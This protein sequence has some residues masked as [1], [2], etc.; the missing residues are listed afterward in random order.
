MRASLAAPTNGRDG[1]L[2]RKTK[3]LIALAIAIAHAA[4]AVSAFTRK[5]WSGSVPPVRKEAVDDVITNFTRRVLR[6]DETTMEDRSRRVRTLVT[7]MA[8]VEA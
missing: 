2:D 6:E 3:E 7:Q 8:P 4:T 1:A 5:R